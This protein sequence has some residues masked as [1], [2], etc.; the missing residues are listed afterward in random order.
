[1]VHPSGAPAFAFRLETAGRTIAYSGDTGWTDTLIDVGRHADLLIN[2]CHSYD[3][4]PAF[5]IDYN[6][7]RSHLGKIHAKRVL[8]THMGEDMLAK[9]DQVTIDAAEDGQLIEL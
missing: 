8:L 1:V 2:E 4:K 7:L 9:L 5:H 3:G 6:T